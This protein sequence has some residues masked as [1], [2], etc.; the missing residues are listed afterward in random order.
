LFLAAAV[1][2]FL[3]YFKKAAETADITIAKVGLVILTILAIELILGFV[4][5]FYRPR[6]PGEEE[7]P[8]IESRLLALF[9]EPGGVARNV[10][11][12]LDYQFGFRV[13]EVWFYRFLERT[14]V[15]LFVAMVILLWL[16]TCLVVI[17]SEEQGIHER[18]G[19]V[20]NQEPLQAGMYFKYP[21]P[22]ARIRRFPVE[23]VQEIE[24]GSGH[25]HQEEEEE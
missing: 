10:A 17:G 18:F 6:M 13:S 20:E 4:I 1:A 22:L 2:L 3:E 9:T 8:L 25:D 5:E 24:L 11:A 15:P 14:L 23:E 12:S 21:W 7:R 19:R 16:Q